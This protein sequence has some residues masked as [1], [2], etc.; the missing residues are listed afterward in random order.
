MS[1]S[2]TKM[3]TEITRLEAYIIEWG[4]GSDDEMFTTMDSLT[5]TI[6]YDSKPLKTLDHVKD[7]PRIYFRD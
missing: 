7:R 6:L 3:L 2:E 1:T 5:R 4:Y